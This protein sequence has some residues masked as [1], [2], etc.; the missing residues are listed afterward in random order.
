[1]EI[2]GSSGCGGCCIARYT[3]HVPNNTTATAAATATAYPYYTNDVSN[4]DRIMLRFRPIAPKPTISGPHSSGSAGST[5]SVQIG[6]GKRKRKSNHNSHNNKRRKSKS[7]DNNKTQEPSNG[8]ESCHVVTL[9]LLPETPDLINPNNNTNDFNNTTKVGSTKSVPTWLC[10]GPSDHEVVVPSTV[11][12]EGVSDAW[13]NETGLGC[14]D[15]ERKRRLEED[16]CPGFISDAWSRVWWTN[17]E[18]RRMVTGEGRRKEVVVGVKLE[19]REKVELNA[20]SLYE[21][22]TCR[23]RVQYGAHTMVVPCDVWRMNGGGFAW[24]LDVK[25]ALTLCL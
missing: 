6:L 5:E 22:F 16:T 7:P 10:F 11:T 12:V 13:L 9:P 14:T 8:G 3:H 20:V 17:E 15:E 24:R 25:A 19:M 21:A 23:V 2:R 18:Y 4:M 1:M